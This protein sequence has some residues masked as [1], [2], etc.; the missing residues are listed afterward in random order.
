MQKENSYGLYPWFTLEKV[1]FAGAV[2]VV[3]CIVNGV[4]LASAAYIASI[5]P[6]PRR[7]EGETE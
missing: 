5:M 6:L 7:L 4:Q 2:P 3:L 1:S